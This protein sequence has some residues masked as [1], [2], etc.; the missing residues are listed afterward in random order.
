MKIELFLSGNCNNND[1]ELVVYCD[2]QPKVNLGCQVQTQHIC[3]DVDDDQSENHQLIIDMQGK[4]PDHTKIDDEG[5]ILEDVV[6][7]VDKIIIDDIDVTDI[8]CKGALCYR[9]DFNGTQEEIVDEFYGVIG[10]NGTIII[11]FTTPIHIWFLEQ[12]E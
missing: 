5:N 1:I 2:E 9:H 4:T 6:V 10:C 3:F 7:N 12:A 11:E 8:F